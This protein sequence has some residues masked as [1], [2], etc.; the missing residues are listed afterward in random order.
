MDKNNQSWIKIGE[1]TNPRELRTE[2]KKLKLAWP[3]RWEF[4]VRPA[5]DERDRSYGLYLRH[6]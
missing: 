6:R 5:S 4:T 3:D 1:S 2:V